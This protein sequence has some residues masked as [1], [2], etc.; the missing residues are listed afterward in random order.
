MEYVHLLRSAGIRVLISVDCYENDTKSHELYSMFNCSCSVLEA[1]EKRSVRS[2][3]PVA[4]IVLL[5]LSIR[6]QA[7]SHL[8]VSVSCVI[9]RN[10]QLL[11]IRFSR[12][13]QRNKIP[14]QRQ[15]IDDQLKN[16]AFI[17]SSPLIYHSRWAKVHLLCF[18]PTAF[19]H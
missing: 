8:T 3:F 7:D 12:I 4:Q 11:Y 2:S 9:G 6:C 5:H 15:D 19:S 1:K 17:S 13:E 16:N 10:Q 18:K 14:I